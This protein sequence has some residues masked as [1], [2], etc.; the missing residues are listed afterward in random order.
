MQN[1]GHVLSC[2]PRAHERPS[3]LDGPRRHRRWPGVLAVTTLT[4]TLL[5]AVTAPAVTARAARD[6]SFCP[7]RQS[8]LISGDGHTL[9]AWLQGEAAN[10]LLHLCWT[11]GGDPTDE[12]HGWAATAQDTAAPG[13]RADVEVLALT[14]HTAIGHVALT[15]GHTW[16]LSFALD[17][18]SGTLPTLSTTIRI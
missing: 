8:V 1:L 7:Q 4:A 3:A 17:A 18:T 10:T 14:A 13:L 15:P 2:A 11:N 5:A 16:R 12:I 6:R 9:R